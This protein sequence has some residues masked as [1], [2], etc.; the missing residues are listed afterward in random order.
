MDWEKA[1]RN[2]DSEEFVRLIQAGQDIRLLATTTK[3]TPLH[4]GAAGGHVNF[5][6]FL[7]DQHVDADAA[8]DYKRTPLYMACMS[9]HTEIVNKLLEK[10]NVN[11]K[12]AC[13]TTA[14]SKAAENGF[15]EILRLLLEKGASI[16]TE[17]QDG[18]SPKDLATR[19]GHLNVLRKLRE[20]EEKQQAMLFKAARNG[21]VSEVRRLIDGGIDAGARSEFGTSVLDQAA[22]NGKEEVVRF[23][24]EEKRVSAKE[25]NKSGVTPLHLAA[26]NGH[27]AVVRL[28]IEN[29]ADP[30]ASDKDNCTP[31]HRAASSGYVGVISAMLDRVDLNVLGPNGRTALH[32]AAGSGRVEVVKLLIKPPRG[33]GADPTKKDNDGKTPKDMAIRFQKPPYPE[34]V[35]TLERV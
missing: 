12:C 26:R 16:S 25:A 17:N 33:A 29:G 24:L 8:D 20:Y 14:V 6:N 7:L 18:E 2:G 28:L 35:Q 4:L 1:A 30:K 22:Q 13:G 27:E 31:L 19:N 32:M 21:L 10:S 11:V 3:V 23:L 5:I 15:V 34:I 9:G